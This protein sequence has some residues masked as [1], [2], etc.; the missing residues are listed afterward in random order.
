M[1]PIEQTCSRVRNFVR[2]IA[3]AGIDSFAVKF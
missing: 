3:A 1:R 2:K